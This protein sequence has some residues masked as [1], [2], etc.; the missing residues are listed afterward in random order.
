MIGF[1]CAF[2]EII[3]SLFPPLFAADLALKVHTNLNIEMV[4][5]YQ[6][7]GYCIQQLLQLL[8]INT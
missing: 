3:P 2:S 5:T 7:V 4:G 6:K 8:H 1:P